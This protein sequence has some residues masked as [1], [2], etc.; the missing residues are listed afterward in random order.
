MNE[1]FLRCGHAQVYVY[2]RKRGCACHC[3]AQPCCDDFEEGKCLFYYKGL[4]L[5]RPKRS[6]E[7]QEE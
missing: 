5:M 2:C 3:C 4:L 1:P 6:D 7:K